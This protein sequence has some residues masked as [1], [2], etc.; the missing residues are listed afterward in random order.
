MSAVSIEPGVIETTPAIASNVSGLA[1]SP[2]I[3][4]AP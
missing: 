1:P 3:S 2:T 4:W